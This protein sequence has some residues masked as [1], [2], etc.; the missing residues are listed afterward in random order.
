MVPLELRDAT[1]EDL[2]AI[3]SLV[4]EVAGE[5]GYPP[6]PEGA[7]ADLYGEVDLYFGD[8][9]MLRVLEESGCL[10]G[11]VGVVPRGAGTW[12]LRKIYL[13]RG[14]RGSGQGRRL[15]EEALSFARSCGAT[16]LVLQSATRLSEALRLYERAGFTRVE[17]A[18]RGT[19]D[20]FMELG[21]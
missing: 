16:R 17:G 11:V 3:R 21:L 14:Q 19:C 15:L 13:Q 1:R 6:E 9:G 12:E 7:D 8:D 20:V 5:Y 18:T 10:L 4:A 2:E